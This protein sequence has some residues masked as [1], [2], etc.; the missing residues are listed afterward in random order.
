MEDYEC[1]IMFSQMNFNTATT[2]LSTL[3][4]AKNAPLVTVMG[5]LYA[6]VI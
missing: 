6:A 4:G 3:V 1:R 2:P 5:L